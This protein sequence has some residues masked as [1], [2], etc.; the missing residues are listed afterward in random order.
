VDQYTYMYCTAVATY[1]H[2]VS[3]WDG[4]D[5]HCNV[6]HGQVDEKCPQI[7]RRPKKKLKF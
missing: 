6:G 1:L 4:E 3:K 7:P 2:G 5:S